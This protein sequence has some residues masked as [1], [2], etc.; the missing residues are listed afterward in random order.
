MSGW[1]SSLVPLK[2]SVSD[3][4]LFRSH[5][6]LLVRGVSLADHEPI[7]EASVVPD[8]ARQPGVAGCFVHA[9]PIAHALPLLS[10]VQGFLRYVPLQYRHCYIDLTG[11]F[12]QYAQKFSGKTRSTIL[13]KV[14]KFEAH[15]GG[16]IKWRVYR[17]AVELKEFHHHARA[18]SEK[19]YQERLLDAG[20]PAEPE[21]VDGMLALAAQD[22]ARGYLLF[23]GER[24][25]SYLYSPVQDGAYLYAYLG[26]DPEYLSWSV[27]TVLQWLAVENMFEE[28]RAPFFDFTEGQSDHKR[29]FA[30][31]E[32]A[33]ANVM[34]VRKTTYALALLYGHA[35]FDRAISALGALAQRWGLKAKIRRLLRASA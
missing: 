5:L 23:D 1:H 30:T 15:S 13:R 29:L 24:P 8:A 6:P 27:G 9:L 28:K 35:G 25:V 11:S 19:T 16:E 26:Y 34:F 3:L 33:C 7:T 14:R 22:Q 4:T 21:F 12:E 20:I 10:T 2:F 31:H 32:V 17:S 18:V